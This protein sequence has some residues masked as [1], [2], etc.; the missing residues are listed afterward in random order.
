MRKKDSSP[1]LMPVKQMY[2]FEI[3]N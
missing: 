3:T 2:L 1:G